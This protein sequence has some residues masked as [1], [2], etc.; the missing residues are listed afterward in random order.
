MT[1]AMDGKNRPVERGTDNWHSVQG[2][3]G[4]RVKLFADFQKV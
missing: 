3:S 4:T 1:N 2:Q